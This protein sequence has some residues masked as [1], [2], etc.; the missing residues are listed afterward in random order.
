MIDEDESSES[1]EFQDDDDEE[2]VH[3]PL[4]PWRGSPDGWVAYQHSD[5]D[6][7]EEEEME[8]ELTLQVLSRII[9]QR[10]EIERW[11]T[12]K[13][14]EDALK[15]AYIRVNIGEDEFQKPKYRLC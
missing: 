7:P 4:A 6:E 12:E 5:E 14:F 9:I 2:S 13:F 8:Q 1:P 3:E 10:N 11:L 15:E